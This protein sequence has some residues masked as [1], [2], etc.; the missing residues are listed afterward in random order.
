MSSGV[1][2]LSDN[3]QQAH[4]V[5]QDDTYPPRMNSANHPTQALLKKGLVMEDDSDYQSSVKLETL[6]NNTYNHAQGAQVLLQGNGV[7]SDHL[8]IHQVSAIT[9]ASASALIKTPASRAL[10]RPSINTSLVPSASSIYESSLTSFATLDPSTADDSGSLISSQ[11][12]DQTSWPS[13][14]TPYSLQKQQSSPPPQFGNH[15]QQL[16]LPPSTNME[17]SSSSSPSS[18]STPGMGSL[19]G[20]NGSTDSAEL[21]EEIAIRRAE[22]NR[23]AQRAFRQRKQKYIKWLESKA[24]EL[25]EV[26]RIMALVR[27]ENQQLC[28]LVLELD[29]KLNGH[30]ATNATNSSPSN[31]E[32]QSSTAMTSG[33]SLQGIDESLGREISIRLMNLATLPGPSLNDDQDTALL[34]KVKYQPRSSALGKPIGAKGRMAYKMSQQSKNHGELLQ[35]ALL[36]SQLLQQQRQQQQH[37]GQQHSGQQHSGQQQQLQPLQQ[38]Q[39]PPLADIGGKS[40]AWEDFSPTMSTATPEASAPFHSAL[41]QGKEDA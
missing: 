33:H 19:S 22:Q 40:N 5:L 2:Y 35:A 39:Q 7:G 26:Y 37:S 17:T 27:A 23:A 4:Y 15:Y 32:V 11:D 41:Q 36:P 29:E 24:E 28:N 1:Q 10:F 34:G 14:M 16:I 6:D 21:P 3:Q 18:T 12:E 9:S 31:R 30:N 20:S 38:H 25:D 13:M 8:S